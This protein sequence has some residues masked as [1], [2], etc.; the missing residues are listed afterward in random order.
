MSY[1]TPPS[2]H[3]RENALA[4]HYGMDATSL[5]HELRKVKHQLSKALIELARERL[6]SSPRNM[7][8]GP[9]HLAERIRMFP[10]A[11]MND[12]LDWHRAEIAYHSKGFS[13]QDFNWLTEAEQKVT[14]NG[15]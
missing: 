6:N 15:S 2:S 7:S 10:N 8:G 4:Y 11:P 9:L 13:L 3:D 12:L 14:L 1:E 5:S